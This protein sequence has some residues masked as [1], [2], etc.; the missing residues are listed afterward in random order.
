[1]TA[2]CCE[3]SRNGEDVS[4]TLTVPELRLEMRD[5]FA[6]MMREAVGAGSGCITLD[7]TRLERIFSLFFGLILDGVWNAR[8]HKREVRIVLSPE[9]HEHFVNMGVQNAAELIRQE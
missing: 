6:R 8:E 7:L 5:D 4:V 9:M 3:L 2:D 1:M